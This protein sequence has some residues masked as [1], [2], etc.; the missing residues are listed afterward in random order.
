ME[1]FGIILETILEIQILF[2]VPKS[3]V[4][5][6][7]K[8]ALLYNSFKEKGKASLG[9]TA[10]FFSHIILPPFLQKKA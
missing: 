3:V 6:F 2:M 7:L 10:L 9:V 1:H 8:A 5:L 4:I